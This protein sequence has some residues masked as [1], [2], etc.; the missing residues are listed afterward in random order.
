MK[1]LIIID[2]EPLIRKY[3]SALLGK[4]YNIVTFKCAEDAISY[5]NSSDDIDHI[6]CDYMMKNIN[7]LELL[8]EIIKLNYF[9]DYTKHFLFMTA[10]EDNQ[11]YYKLISTGCRVVKKTSISQ[12]LL[13]DI[14]KSYE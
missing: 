12:D 8:D 6:L 2:D 11:V 14:F 5:I 3:L 13:E 4:K 9:N 10:Y 7:G 1:K